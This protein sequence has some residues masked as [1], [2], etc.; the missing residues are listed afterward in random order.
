MFIADFHIHSRYSRATSKDCVPEL[1]ELWARRKG[2]DL[3]GTGD[4]TH[5]AW[6]EELREKLVPAEEGLYTLKDEFRREE[7]AAGSG[8]KPRFLVSGEISS[9]YKKNGKVR[10]VHNV[11]LLPSLEAAETLSHRLEAIGG[12]LHSDGRPILG[13]DSRDLLEIT[14]DVCPDAIFIP[15][16]IWTPH[17]S[18][19]GA[20]SGFDTIEECFGDLTGCIHALETGLSSDPPMNWRVSALDRFTLV[21]DSDAHSPANLARE[22]NL[23]DTGLSYPSISRALQ[24]RETKEFAGTIEFFPEEGKYHYDGHRNCG[25]CLKPADTDAVSGV[26]PVCGGRITVGVLHRVE[27]LA[28]R[29]EGFVPPLSKPFE[30][31]V[32][33]R[34]VI[35]ASVGLTAASGK[36]GSQY[37]DLLRTL[38]PELFILREA[39]PGDIELA[40]GPLVAEGI[41]RL[42]AGK[43]EVLPGY[44]GEYGKIKILDRQEIGLLSGQLYLFGAERDASAPERTPERKAPAGKTSPETAA[45]RAKEADTA[46]AAAPDPFAGLNPEQRE[47]VCA[48]DR[49]VAVIAGPGTGKTR[50]LVS[51]IVRLVR[52]GAAPAQITAVTFTNRA[53]EEMRSRLSAQLGDR[54][55][56]KAMHIGTFH[57]ICL[58]LLS[59]KNGEVPT[60]LDEQ[61]ALSILADLLRD[62]GLKAS[63]RDVLSG[64]SLIKS[65]AKTPQEAPEVPPEVYERYCGQ[66]AQYGVLDYDDILLNAL[67]RFEGGN[68]EGKEGKKLRSAFTH[69]LVDEFQDINPVQYRLIR[70][71]GKNS[72][73]IFVI[74]DPDQSI[75]GFRGSD[76]RCFERFFED[77]PGARRVRLTQNYRSTP[78]ILG[79]ARSVLAEKGAAEPPLRAQREGG[80]KVRL[81]TADGDLPEA[82][83]V[84]KEIDRMVGGIDMLDTSSP[85]KGK[86]PVPEQ[87]RSF[88]DIAVLYRTNRQAEL[89]EQC[90][91]KEG[92]PYLV[93]GRDEFLSDREVRKTV[94][95]F[96]FLLDPADLVS[97]R[98]C[99]KEWEV[100]P[101]GRTQRILQD[102]AGTDK[103]V[104]SLLKLMEGLPASPGNPRSFSELLRKYEPLA[105]GEKPQKLIEA[106][107]GD[108]GLEDVRSMGLFLNMAVL[109][110][111]MPSLLQNL[112]LGREGDVVRSGGRSYSPDAVSLMTLHA[113]KGLE[114]PV[115]F[116]S[117]VKDGTIPLRNRRGDCDPDEERRLFYVGMTRAQDEL[118]LLTSSAPSPFLAGLPADLLSSGTAFERKKAP[119]FEQV[120]F[121]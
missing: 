110:E 94:A 86:K 83:F 55:T 57:S 61:D 65:G 71:W 21:S 88:S 113:A 85:K 40:A 87:T 76:S 111:K 95:F 109:H 114:F 60:I 59:G 68:P 50:T 91:G 93:A 118:V 84:A 42:R 120:S 15:A 81:L 30:S 41:R 18:L 51:R 32:P 56:V 31:L 101:G 66:L 115:V 39:Q 23:F 58:Q 64:I 63:P 117:G 13:L 33:L 27:S 24:N 3:I 17:F 5:P 69:L 75:Y 10:K 107:I 12:N 37:D 8:L 103:S 106:W 29:A 4:F 70:A 79:C 49:A 25:V 98:L 35:A 26:C 99:L 90:L 96:R 2:L 48:P 112:L 36:V 45:G 1:L 52:D 22:A 67:E 82:I 108:N 7:D 92:I 38:G 72:A 19:F 116:V 89:L 53:E 97:L 73:G 44:D 46:Q 121:F 104:A 14:L 105:P 9:I 16:H 80:A 47:A 74:G 34:E 102:Y 100:C 28:D 54:R 20:Y 62:L 6:R 119:E 77:F 78:E 11:I 43:V